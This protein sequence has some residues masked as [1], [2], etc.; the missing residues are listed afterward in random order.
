[1]EVGRVRV[2]LGIEIG[3]VRVE[4][5]RVEWKLESYVTVKVGRFRV[6]FGRPR[7]GVER[8]RMEVGRFRV[9]VSRSVEIRSYALQWVTLAVHGICFHVVHVS[10]VNIHAMHL[11]LCALDMLLLS[12]AV[13]E[14]LAAKGVRATQQGLA[15]M[16]Y[17]WVNCL[18][19]FKSF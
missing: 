15:S 18:V 11:R 1:M 5:G 7:V 10:K 9:K 6:E 16:S 2:K 4:V 17:Y 3:R 14:A 12:L 19:E 8:V 13:S